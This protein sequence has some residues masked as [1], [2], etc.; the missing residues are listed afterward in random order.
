MLTAGVLVDYYPFEN[1]FRLSGGAYYNDNGFTGN[2]K[3]S[4]DTTIDINGQEY[5]VGD[6]GSLDSAVSFDKVAPYIGLGWGNNAHD[7]GWGFTFDLGVMY[8]GKGEAN[9]T[10]LDISPLIDKDLLE[11][12]VVKEE[13]DIND[14]L[15]KI[16]V[17]PVVAIGVNYSF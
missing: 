10:P 11:S 17:Y 7:K 12:N 9:L 8:H 13:Q 15:H 3:P 2:I 6:I 4:A 1:N 14:D 5:Q 16:K